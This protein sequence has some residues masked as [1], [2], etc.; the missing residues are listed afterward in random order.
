MRIAL[1][2]LLL[3]AAACNDVVTCDNETADVGPICLP[4]L[5]APQIQ[6]VIEVQE[7]CGKGCSGTPSCTAL[8]NGGRVVLDV[9]QDVCT[10]STT[11]SCIDLGCQQRVMRCALPPLDPGE[12]TLAAPGAPVQLLRVGAGGQSS[13][14]F[15]D[16]DGGVQ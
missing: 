12:Y 9:T 16:A 4:S 1:A 15:A 5:L 7:L 13:C 11:G 6:S 2:A 8:W 10:D 3:L 14:R